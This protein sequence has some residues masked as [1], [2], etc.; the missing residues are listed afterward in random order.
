MTYLPIFLSTHWPYRQCVDISC[1]CLLVVVVF[2]HSF[3]LLLKFFSLFL[4][5]QFHA[6]L[7]SSSFHF[8]F[9][10]S[11]TVSVPQQTISAKGMISIY[12]HSFYTSF[13]AVFTSMYLQSLFPY[14]S[15][16]YANY[17]ILWLVDMVDRYS[18]NSGA[19]SP[20]FREKIIRGLGNQ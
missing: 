12:F 1:C 7:L 20:Q 2:P 8:S 19:L 15:F 14:L 16:L 6:Y 4:S 9:S 5:F 3:S 13:C 18:C 10:G 17:L 11:F